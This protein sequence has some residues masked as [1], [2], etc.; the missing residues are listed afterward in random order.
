VIRRALTSSGR[1]AG[2]KLWSR[3]A[4]ATI[5]A[6][7]F[8][9]MSGSKGRTA[10]GLVF[11]LAM[12]LSA[13]GGAS[14]ARGADLRLGAWLVE[15]GRSYALS[16][17][18]RGTEADARIALALMLAASQVERQT[19][20][21]YWWQMQLGNLLGERKISNDALAMYCLLK[22]LDLTRRIM[23]LDMVVAERQTAEDRLALLERLLDVTQASGPLTISDM[24]RR[25]AE[26]QY[27][28]G[29]TD[30]ADEHI[31]LALGLFP[32]NL[33][34]RQLR[35]EAHHLIPPRLS[36]AVYRLYL[37]EENPTSWQRCVDLAR[38]L[39]C[40]GL[41][42]EAREW[43]EYAARLMNRV[44]LGGVAVGPVML[45]VA[46][47]FKSDGQIEDAREACERALAADPE[48]TDARLLLAELCPADSEE[49]TCV[50]SQAW[51]EGH[52]EETAQQL[53]DKPDAM[54]AASLSWIYGRLRGDDAKAVEYGDMA[55]T[56]DPDNPV[57]Q[58]VAGYARLW[59]GE[60]DRAAELL[61]GPAAVDALAAAGLGQA[62]L[63]LD[64]QE[65]GVELLRNVVSGCLCG[66]AYDEAAKALERAEQAPPPVPETGIL[67]AMLQAFDR[68]KL[69]F[70]FDPDQ[71][72]LLRVDLVGD[73]AKGLE[74]WEFQFRVQ[75]RSEHNVSVGPGQMLDP[76]VLLSFE[77]DGEVPARFEAYTTVDLNQ[78]PVLR[79]G[80]MIVDTQ[81]VDTGLL[82]E[83]LWRK[84][85]A[86]YRVRVEAIMSP[87]RGEDGRWRPGPFAPR[88]WVF[89]FRRVGLAAA[90]ANLDLLLDAAESEDARARTAAV[91]KLVALWAEDQA[92]ESGEAGY[93]AYAVDVD[94][95]RE[96]VTRR[97][98]DPDQG[99]RL[100]TLGAL[101]LVNLSST[102]I[103]ALASLLAH[104]DP[105]T[106]METVL[107]MADQQGDTFLP[108]VT[109]MAERD[110][111]PLVR[112]LCGGLRDNWSHT[113]AGP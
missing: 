63:Q 72:L 47:S 76:R 77:L 89:E 87:V 9:S 41:R 71:F 99:V 82:R 85:Q 16:S 27:S 98:D 109:A 5:Q 107:L 69:D 55:V 42:R 20:S 84:A 66:E 33:A 59:S 45:Q 68:G 105:V 102:E 1:T 34:A 88:P 39:D 90:A 96:A 8:R 48:L 65:K 83:F 110:P 94:R 93:D 81:I 2:R 43:Y 73:E 60:A 97:W 54:T 32:G 7:M 101:R 19:V 95:I 23:W 21:A 92:R 28:L 17:Q 61:A 56:L 26:L 104:E 11:G 64:R 22:P 50:Q 53:A 15:E 31:R 67:A 108:V 52:I 12:V 40:L 24:H 36:E 6:E 112:L 91:R 14:T 29:Q 38:E 58:S 4:E 106:R 75:N 49:P 30:K 51:L 103:S 100:R 79:G 13:V 78:R 37:V 44:R 46:R 111:D 18:A 10:G 74:P 113:E 70:A 86:N 25:I 62:Y 57:A 80:Q 35:D 3:Q